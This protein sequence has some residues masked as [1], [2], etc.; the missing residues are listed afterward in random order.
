MS[1]EVASA[2]NAKFG[3]S[4]LHTHDLAGDDTVVVTREI[5]QDVARFLKEDPALAFNMPIDCTGVDYLT[6][7][8]HT[9]PRF[10]VVYHFYSTTLK[11]RIR[12]K[13]RLEADD[14]TMPSLQPIYRGFDWFEREVWDMYGVHFEG[15]HDLRRIL[16]YPEFV[17]H[18]LRKDY[19]HRGYQ[20]LI[21][22]SRLDPDNEDPKLSDV[23]LNPEAPRE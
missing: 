4:V 3:S 15:H 8:G 10:E 16:L 14:P 23:D 19:P 18:P 2:L 13:V 21:P 7:P 17:G 1:A 9:G 5:V 20:P 6:F 12:V 22:V 11:H